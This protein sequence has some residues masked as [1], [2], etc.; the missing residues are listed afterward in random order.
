MLGCSKLADGLC[1]V[2]SL[3]ASSAAKRLDVLKGYLS[4]LS[5]QMEQHGSCVCNS[6]LEGVS[7]GLWLFNYLSHVYM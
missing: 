6:M 5:S 3:Y 1:L 4:D 7:A 2:M